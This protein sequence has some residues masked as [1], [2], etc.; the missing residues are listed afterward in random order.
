MKTN[1]IFVVIFAILS[2]G[3]GAFLA[4]DK[5]DTLKNSDAYAASV[6]DCEWKK[7]RSTGKN[8]KGSTRNSYA[9]VAVS[10]QGYRAIGG[11][12]VSSRSFCEK[13]IGQEVTIL[14]DRN[15]TEKTRIKSFSQ[16]WFAPFVLLGGIAFGLACIF[17]RR[18]IATAIFCGVFLFAGTSAAIE[19]RVFGSPIEDPNLQPVDGKKA[20]KT[21]IEQ[22]MRQENT[23]DSRDLKKLTCKKRSLTDLSLLGPLI[24][25]EELNL[26]SNQI[27]SLEPLGSLP[28]LRIL[29]LDGNRTLETLNG[30]QGLKRLETLKVH[31][32]G[33]V[34]IDAVKDL[35]NLRHLDVSCNKISSLTPI[36]KLDKLEKLIM[37]DN[38]NI[39][40]IIPVSNK[41]ELETITLY[42]VPVSDISPLYG[43]DKLWR[44]NIGDAGKVP[45]EQ[46][47][48]L[49]S[50]L[51][52]S[53]QIMGPKACAKN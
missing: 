42:R 15:D 23:E 46:I 22:A 29:T 53:A 32:A 48:K 31:C 37:D 2:A 4:K 6:V 3:F 5:I 47:Y 17:Q 30:L 50:G 35:K 26:N 19:F 45:C 7:Q 44:A 38:P 13:M 1:I 16:F 8:R 33:L 24:S 18:I 49:R 12:K 21:C 28:Q 43:N 10:E 11:L 14:V 34:E 36:T 41:P 40:S 9:P 39:T 52:K 25:L 27:T 51:V 20:L